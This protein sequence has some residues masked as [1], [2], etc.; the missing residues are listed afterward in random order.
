MLYSQS[1]NSPTAIVVGIVGPIGC[2]RELIIETFAKLAP[3]YSYKA[4]VVKVSEIIKLYMDV[5]PDIDKKGQY[6][7][8][9]RLMDAGN[10]LRQ[11]AGD[12]SIL[13]KMS[14]LEIAKKRR[15][16]D[17]R[18]IYIVDSL[19]H[20]E[21]ISALRD[22]YGNG[23]YLF[24][25]HSEESNRDLFLKNFCN[26]KDDEE[27]K[28][29]I[30][31][32][33]DEELGNG[34]STSSSFHL[35]DFFLAEDGNHSKI[36]NSLERYLDLMFGN[37]FRTPTFYEYSM[38]MAHAASIRSAD[39]SRQVGAVITQGTDVISSGANEC[40]KPFGGTYWPL[41]ND[42]T[43]KIYDEPKGRDYMLGLDYNAH[44][45]NKMIEDLK[46]NI[47]SEYLE[48]LDKNI[49]ASGL[50]DITEYGRVV[51]A[52]MDAIL[53]CARRGNSTKDTNMFCTT[54]PCH[55][56]AKHIVA[57][58]IRNVV[59]IEPYPKSKALDMHSDAISVDK[60]SSS[61][62]V[63][64]RPFIGVGPRQYINLFSMNLSAGSELKRK[65]KGSSAKVNWIQSDAVPRVKLFD[66]SYVDIELG[67]E[68]EVLSKFPVTE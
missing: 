25:V 1:E 9:M 20:P 15:N 2:N 43:K 41:F 38:F 57:S 19:K 34:Q 32:D 28:N 35:A 30:K 42:E 68:E 21:E 59:Y 66:K 3:H 54:Y 22:A 61:S 16:N 63:L 56:C 67:L 18:F 44:Q 12:N 65:N 7:R 37:P 11:K 4:E 10:E 51:H 47:P 36:W 64:F 55:N 26:I 53:G 29:L 23:F 14:I 5:D 46:K 40:P 50:K 60:A 27:R 45:K 49:K 62:H 17:D 58:G 6:H 8:V 13:A 24:A 31:R 52:E 39:L 48:T 33:K